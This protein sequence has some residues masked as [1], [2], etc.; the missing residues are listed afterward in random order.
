GSARTMQALKGRNNELSRPFR[1]RGIAPDLL[2]LL[3]RWG[4]NRLGRLLCLPGA[5]LLK[6]V[7]PLPICLDPLPAV[8]LDLLTRLDELPLTLCCLAIGNEKHML[9]L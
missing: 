6:L 9:S 8:V 1:A 4:W 2:A 3:L 5:T 7:R